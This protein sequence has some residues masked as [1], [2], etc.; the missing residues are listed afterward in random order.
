MLFEL[1][2][3]Q[4]LYAALVARDAHFDGNAYVGVSTTGI[5][6]RLTCPARKPKPE[7][8]TFFASTG[9][10]IEAGFRPCKRCHPVQAAALA[11]PIIASLLRALDERPDLRWSES[12]LGQF[13]YEPSTVRRSFKRHFGMTFLEMARQRRLRE[14]FETLAS[15][16]KVITAQHDASFESALTCPG[17]SGQARVEFP[18]EV[19]GFVAL[20]GQIPRGLIE[21]RNGR[22]LD[23]VG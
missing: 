16:G 7:Y 8:C 13:G 2:D 22:K 19:H 17:F 9:E 5:F 12:H 15:G 10:C 14:G 18:G 1:P 23:A 11:D 4:T 21:C 6:C 20:R 3:F